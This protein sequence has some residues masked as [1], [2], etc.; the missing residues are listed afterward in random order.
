[1]EADGLSAN[2]CMYKIEGEQ[3]KPIPGHCEWDRDDENWFATR[4]R[5]PSGFAAHAIWENEQRRRGLLRF[6]LDPANEDGLSC[7]F[8]TGR[9]PRR[10]EAVRCVWGGLGQEARLPRARINTLANHGWGLG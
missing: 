10:A 2:H 4:T 9:S 3:R 6:K 7:P 8:A 5:S 1:M